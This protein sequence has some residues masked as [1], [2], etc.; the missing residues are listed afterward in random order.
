MNFITR[1]GRTLLLTAA[2]MCLAAATVAQTGTTI[3][4][5]SFD[6]LQKIGTTADYPMD[7]NYEL[8]TDIDAVSSRSRAFSPILFSGTFDGKDHTING[9]YIKRNTGNDSAGLFG[10]TQKAT[11]RNVVLAVDSIVGILNVGAL[12]GIANNT[13]IENCHVKSG[14]VG[15]QSSVGGLV[16]IAS[17]TTI[18]NSSSRSNCYAA[19]YKGATWESGAVGGLVGQV[20]EGSVINDSY[21]TGNVTS[22][23]NNAGGLVGY[24][25]G[26]RITRCYSTGNVKGDNFVGGL[27]GFTDENIPTN[28]NG[29]ICG[30]DLSKDNDIRN[31]YSVSSVNGSSEIGGLVGG[32]GGTITDSYAT[33]SVKGSSRNSIGGLVGHNFPK[34]TITK[35]YAVGTVSGGS[36][37]SSD[38]GGFAGYNRG[39]GTIRD[40]YWDTGTSGLT[41]SGG[42]VGRTTAQM[43]T[44]STYV[45]WDFDTVWM[46]NEG[47]DYPSLFGFGKYCL[48]YRVGPGGSIA[49]G[50]TIQ[51]VES[52]SRGSTV[53]AMPNDGYEF[54]NWSDG[55]ANSIRTDSNVTSN[56]ILTANFCTADNIKQLN[57]K[58]GPGGT[59]SGPASQKICGTS[60]GLPVTAVPNEGYKFVEWSDGKKDAARTDAGVTASVEFTASFVI[61]TYILVYTAGQ[62]GTLIGGDTIMTVA[63]GSDGGLVLALADDGYEFVK[64]SDDVTSNPR[65]D[66]NVGANIAVSAVFDTL[67]HNLSYYVSPAHGVLAGSATQRVTHGSNG[68]A[69]Y[70]TG[71][72]GYTFF[73][74]SDGLKD[75]IRTDKNVQADIAVAA[76]FKD[77]AGNVSV[78]SS[79]RVIPPVNPSKEF[80]VIT[81]IAALTAEF[82]AGPNPAGKSSAGAVN[83]FRTGAVIKSATLHVYDVS[84]NIVKKIS[85]N[86][87]AVVGV[88]SK[89]QVGSWDLRD[90]K[91]RS[92]SDGTYL[93]RGAVKT[94]DGKSEKV[95][96]AVGVR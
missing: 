75:S 95:S 80:S 31:S 10:R 88:Q 12:V 73:E 14:Y 16:G 2:V 57:Y 15:G 60:R 40:S 64:W 42:G 83:F 27:I 84:G 78:S 13:T 45:G 74:W 46:I 32:N 71:A 69:V 63:H 59:V 25:G 8:T 53:V 38:V 4:I 51:V 19:G 43:K 49:I 37:T 7:G 94:R 48:R 30:I 52:G 26:V 22:A 17:G 18:K 65:T 9:L 91:G 21:A 47:V 35:C 68:S 1:Q 11:I 29:N 54:T 90:K 86:D 3:K 23:L 93:V 77:A 76:I 6:D 34:G 89:R 41:T 85:I 33:G 5:S 56:K 72:N 79:D 28:C 58:A 61:K 70:V 96:V 92:V 36:G 44:K 50:D 67:R 81:P 82:T 55:V 87:K 24:C 39:G 62:N 20:E 66:K